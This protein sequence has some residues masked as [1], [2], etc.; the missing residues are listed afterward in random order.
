MLRNSPWEYVASI[1]VFG[2]P[3]EPLQD[4]PKSRE[5]GLRRSSWE[6]FTIVAPDKIWFDKQHSKMN[7]VLTEI[8][9][10]PYLAMRFGSV[11]SV[12]MITCSLYCV[13]QSTK[14]TFAKQC[15]RVTSRRLPWCAYQPGTVTIRLVSVN[16]LWVTCCAGSHQQFHLKHYLFCDYNKCLSFHLQGRNYWIGGFYRKQSIWL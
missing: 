14:T 6:R 3:K 4:A 8:R 2:N 12:P 13:R 11:H 15:L 7:C 9:N 1:W 10:Q 16:L 5:S